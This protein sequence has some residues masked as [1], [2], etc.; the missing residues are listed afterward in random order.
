MADKE[1]LIGGTR[2]MYGTGVKVSPELSDKSTNTFDGAVTQ[3]LGDV[4][5]TI[6]ISKLSYD[7]M[8]TTQQLEE[9][10]ES[11]YDNPDIVTV[12]ER[13]KPKGE[14]PFWRV[15][16]FHNCIVSDNNYEIKPDDLTVSNLK[17]RAAKRTRNY[18]KA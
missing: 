9:K 4:P 17:F 10:I 13:V 6:E 1:V 7:G 8:T 12:R 3:G 11:M 18:R 16:N 2:M 5:Y 15:H 14:A